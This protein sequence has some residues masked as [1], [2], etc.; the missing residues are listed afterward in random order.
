ME[1]GLSEEEDANGSNVWPLLQE[2][3]AVFAP[4]RGELYRGNAKKL[5]ESLAVMS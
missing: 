5:Q 2:S 1:R 4:K 3:L